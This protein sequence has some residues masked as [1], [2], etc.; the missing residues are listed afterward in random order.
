MIPSFT[1]ILS[2][3]KDLESIFWTVRH[4]LLNNPTEASIK[5]AEVLGELSHI[6]EFVE[7]ETVGYLEIY[8]IDD[9]SNFVQCRSALLSLESGYVTIKGYEARGHCHKINNIY[10]KYLDRWFNKVLD[11]NEV[12]QIKLLFEKMNMADGDMIDG[13][14]EITRWLKDESEAVLL[15]VDDDKLSEANEK[16]KSARLPIQ[17]TRRNI[18]EALAELKLLQASFIVSA[19]TV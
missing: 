15:L 10:E 5:L 7:K 8:F 2:T 12:Q 18:V 9:K 19:Q 14:K 13:I 1:S 11:S 17:Q 3:A 4:K 16:I 6:L